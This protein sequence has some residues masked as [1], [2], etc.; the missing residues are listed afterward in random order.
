MAV[1]VMAKVRSKILEAFCLN[2]ALFPSAFYEKTISPQRGVV[3]AVLG[4]QDNFCA[5]R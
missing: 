4:K 5:P 3:R 1:L 2:L